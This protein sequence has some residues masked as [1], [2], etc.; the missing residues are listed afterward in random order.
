MQILDQQRGRR[1]AQPVKHLAEQSEPCTAA[2]RVIQRRIVDNRQVAQDSECCSRTPI[3][4]GRPHQPQ[5][6]FEPGGGCA[7]HAGFADTR[8]ADDEGHATMAGNRTGRQAI[9]ILENGV[10]LEQ[11]GERY[12]RRKRLPKIG[13]AKIGNSRPA[14]WGGLPMLQVEFSS[15]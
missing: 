14:K 3:L 13:T 6:A 11:H 1:V 10:A 15:I 2:L 7:Q 12:N 8:F 4:A 9:Q 5:F